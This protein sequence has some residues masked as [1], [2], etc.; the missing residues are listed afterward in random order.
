MNLVKQIMDQFSGS[1]PWPTWLAP[2]HR[3]GNYGTCGDRGRAVA[4]FR[5]VGIG[6]DR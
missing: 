3:C 6:V 4:A 2:G 1:A 5:L